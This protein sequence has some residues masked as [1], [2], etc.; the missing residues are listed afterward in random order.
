[1]AKPWEVASIRLPLPILVERIRSTILVACGL[2]DQVRA[3]LFFI[4]R[5][6]HIVPHPSPFKHIAIILNAILWQNHKG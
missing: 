6:G 4:E 5:I 3:T 1:M 2:L